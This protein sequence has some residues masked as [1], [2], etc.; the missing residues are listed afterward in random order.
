MTGNKIGKAR[1][2]NM[3][4]ACNAGD[5]DLI[6]G[7]GKPSGEG[8]RYLLQYSCLENFPEREAWQAIYNGILPSHKK[9]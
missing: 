9:E 4:F 5:P 6:L 8:K 3:L 7:S 1:K 2:D